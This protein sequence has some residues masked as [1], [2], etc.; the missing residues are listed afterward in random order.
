MSASDIEP[1]VCVECGTSGSDVVKRRIKGNQLLCGSCFASYFEARVRSTVSHKFVRAKRPWSQHTIYVAVSGSKRSLALFYALSRMYPSSLDRSFRVQ[2]VFVRKFATSKSSPIEESIRAACASVEGSLP[3]IIVDALSEE[4]GSKWDSLPDESRV[5]MWRTAFMVALGKVVEGNEHPLCI[6]TAESSETLA[7]RCLELTSSAR[8]SGVVCF[9]SLA[10]STLLKDTTKPVP[11]MRLFGDLLTTEIDEYAAMR[12]VEAIN[13]TKERGQLE[14]VCN[15]F[16]ESMQ[17]QFSHMAFTVVSTATK[18][19][20][21]DDYV[22]CHICG[23]PVQKSSSSSDGDAAAV[24]DDTMETDERVAEARHVG[25]KHDDTHK[26]V[27]M[28]YACSR[29]YHGAIN[30]VR[31]DDIIIMERFA[32]TVTSFLFKP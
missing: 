6:V 17:K 21:S 19:G 30:E 16:C 29:M 4:I 23:I 10:D 12:H 1:N 24:A 7:S 25:L 9:C 3:L 31:D 32:Q 26:V 22:R 27:C 5:I 2:P 11:V 8:G 20:I 13:T 15:G 28:C 18:L 14:N